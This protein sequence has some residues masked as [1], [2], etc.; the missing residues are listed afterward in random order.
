MGI[1]SMPSSWIEGPAALRWRFGQ[2]TIR[3]LHQEVDGSHEGYCKITDWRGTFGSFSYLSSITDL[4]DTHLEG[5]F[6]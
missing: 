3:S 2:G 4:D 6:H 5:V 1:R